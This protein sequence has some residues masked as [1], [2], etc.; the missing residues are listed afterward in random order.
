MFTN[1]CNN[2]NYYFLGVLNKKFYFE[3]NL[4]FA[5][6]SNFKIP[7]SFQ[8]DCN[9]LFFQAYNNKSSKFIVWDT[10][11]KIYIRLQ[12]YGLK[13]QSLGQN[14]HFYTFLDVQF[15]N[16]K[17]SYFWATSKCF[18]RGGRPTTTIYP[19]SHT[20]IFVLWISC[21]WI[22]QPLK[23]L[24]LYRKIVFIVLI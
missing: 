11:Y 23:K 21:F 15:Q 22:F 5:S 13:N 7:L 14:D 3:K 6:N 19:P 16:T 12:R 2:Q 18:F 9:S 10:R 24:I 8:P 4:I 1:K 20:K 17:I